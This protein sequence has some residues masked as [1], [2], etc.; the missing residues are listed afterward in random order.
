MNDQSGGFGAERRVE[1]KLSFFAR[2]PEEADN[3]RR[4]AMKKLERKV[5]EK[6]LTVGLCGVRLHN[7]LE[8]WIS[9]GYVKAEEQF[10]RWDPALGGS[11]Q[12]V[13][14]KGKDIADRWFERYFTELRK[15]QELVYRGSSLVHDGQATTPDP[16]GAYAQRDL[17]ESLLEN[18]LALA[19]SRI[20]K[21]HHDGV[22]IQEMAELE[23]LSVE[24]M[25]RRMNRAQGKARQARERQERALPLNTRPP[26][27]APKPP[28]KADGFNPPPKL[29]YQR[30]R[31][32]P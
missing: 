20:L 12:W 4:L 31:L 2:S 22:E 23:G 32:K 1:A 11:V 25:Q 18:D 26:G 30:R 24:T 3:I 21:L 15:Y 10:D 9:E 13:Y 16:S 28:A 7:C 29:G 5:F 14:L 27:L 8:D 17:V 19:D 6:T